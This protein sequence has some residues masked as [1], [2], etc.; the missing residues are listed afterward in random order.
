MLNVN[1]DVRNEQMK[2]MLRDAQNERLAREVREQSSMLKNVGNTR[3]II[4][5]SLKRKSKKVFWILVL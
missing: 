1:Y 4:G 2:D 5:K 3:G